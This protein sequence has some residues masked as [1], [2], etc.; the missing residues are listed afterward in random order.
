[1][2]TV[3]IVGAGQAGLQLALGLQAHGY[4]VTLMTGR[5]PEEI[6]SGRMTIPQVVFPTALR[7]ERNQGLDLWSETAPAIDGF[8]VAIGAPN[9]SHLTRWTGRLDRPARVIDQRLKFAAWLDLYTD[10]GGTV[11]QHHASVSDLDWAAAYYDLVV[12]ATGRSGLSGLFPRSAVRSPFTVPQRNYAAAQVHGLLPDP[13]SDT[14]PAPQPSGRPG[15][16]GH[17]GPHS[18][19]HA[20]RLEILPGVGELAIMPMLSRSGPCDALLLEAVPGGPLDLFVGIQDPREHLAVM[21]GLIRRRFPSHY[22]RVGPGVELTDPR[23]ALVGRRTPVVR[24][25]VGILPSGGAV[26]GIGDAVL[27]NDPITLLGASSAA[28]AANHCLDRILAHGTLPFDRAFMQDLHET[29]WSRHGRDV[30]DL[31][32]AMLRPLAPHMVRLLCAAGGHRP[33]ADG[34]A[35][36]FDSPGGIGSWFLD[37]AGVDRV[38]SIFGSEEPEAVDLAAPKGSRLSVP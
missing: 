1:M 11:I 2:R 6:E 31:S 27:A 26:L 34:F 10:G 3:L 37:E 35:N 29:G 33:L 19:R 13:E 12:V 28:K 4:G 22:R 7:Y 15:R 30:T 8:G 25:P 21:L 9:G 20:A 18:L 16:A 5:S 36:A 17:S 38:V 24:E 23:A 14:A 32:N